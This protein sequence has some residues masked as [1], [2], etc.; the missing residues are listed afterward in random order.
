MAKLDSKQLLPLLT[1]SFEL[2]G[3]LQLSSDSSITGSISGSFK[4][5]GDNLTFGPAKQPFSDISESLGDRLD[6]IEGDSPQQLGETN[7]PT[8]A[9]LSITNGLTVGGDITAESFIVSSSVTHMTQSF[10]SGS[11]VFGD[12]L[13]DTHEFTGSL[14]FTGSMVIPVVDTFPTSSADKPF[15]SGS[16]FYFDEGTGGTPSRPS[17]QVYVYSGASSDGF[18]AISTSG[19]SGTSG[20]AGTSG[21][22]GSSGT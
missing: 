11:T 21:T 10:S 6:T 14:I 20:T 15:K 9:G 13:D 5:E 1:G 19:T 18:N 7:T 12:T 8:F 4:G 2:S 17:K 3:S 16:I 22:S